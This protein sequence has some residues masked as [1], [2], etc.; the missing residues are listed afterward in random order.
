MQESSFSSPSTYRPV[1]F[2]KKQVSYVPAKVKS[3]VCQ[4]VHIVNLHMRVSFL[5]VTYKG[6]SRG[7]VH[8]FRQDILDFPL[9]LLLKDGNSL[10][11]NPRR[12]VEENLGPRGGYLEMELT[13]KGLR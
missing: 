2:N 11:K 9:R 13:L 4:I 10:Q 12:A 5:E 1:D 7:W 8:L 6:T 3:G